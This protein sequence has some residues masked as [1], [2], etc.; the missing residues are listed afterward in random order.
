MEDGYDM[1]V[2]DVKNTKHASEVEFNVFTP[3]GIQSQQNHQIQEVANIIGQ[4]ADAT[5]I[6]LRHSKWN[7]ERLIEQYMDKQDELLDAAGLGTGT[8]SPPIIKVVP[9]FTCDICCQD[10]ADLATFALKCDHRFCVDCYRHYLT[11]KIKDEGEAARIRCP[12]EQCQRVLDTK[13][14]S[15]LLSPDI[16]SR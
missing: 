7:K 15:L 13:S 11:Q 6:L 2:K 14:I 16:L 9:G 8:Q 10:D 5:A 12:G 4:P 1:V 3:Q